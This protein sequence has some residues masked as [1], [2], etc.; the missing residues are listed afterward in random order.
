[1]SLR[2]IPHMLAILL[3]G[4]AFGA[5]WLV[6]LAS[7]VPLPVI[8]LRAAAGAAVFWLVGLIVGKVLVSS[9][10]AAIGEHMAARQHKN[11]A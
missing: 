3:S 4:G 6:G 8:A 9:V 7:D 11:G 10:Y 5:A 1:M 2:L